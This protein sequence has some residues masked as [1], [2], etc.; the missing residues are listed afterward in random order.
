MNKDN[1]FET[2]VGATVIVFCIG[3]FY[4]MNSSYSIHKQSYLTLNAKFNNADGINLGTDIKISGVKIGKVSSIKLDPE[5]FNAIIKLDINSKLE[6]PADS[7][8]I[9]RTNGL[10]GSRYIEIGVG[11]SEELMKNKS[12]F[13]STQSSILIEDILGKFLLNFNKA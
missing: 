12:F 4:F 13:T 5:T 6:I 2:I 9:I 3:F 1:F 11:G 10:I 7:T 8:A